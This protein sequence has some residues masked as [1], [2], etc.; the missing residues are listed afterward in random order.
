M[1]RGAPGQSRPLRARWPPWIEERLGTS[2]RD[3]RKKENRKRPSPTPV[4][5]GRHSVLGVWTPHLAGGFTGLEVFLDEGLP[6]VLDRWGKAD[7]LMEQVAIRG[8]Q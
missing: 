2:W 4:D 1:C 3:L 6:V 8:D 5:D 7:L